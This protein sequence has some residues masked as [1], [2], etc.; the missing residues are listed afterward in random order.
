MAYHLWQ[1]SR[2]V[3][4]SASEGRYKIPPRCIV[5]RPDQ[6]QYYL[7]RYSSYSM[8]GIILRCHYPYFEYLLLQ[9]HL[10]LC[11]RGQPRRCPPARGGE[12][13]EENAVARIFSRLASKRGITAAKKFGKVL[14]ATCTHAGGAGSAEHACLQRKALQCNASMQCNAEQH[15]CRQE[16]QRLH[17]QGISMHGA[18]MHC[19]RTKRPRRVEEAGQQGKKRASMPSCT[20]PEKPAGKAAREEQHR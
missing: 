5:G 15:A 1:H 7:K 17:E 3:D 2:V 8:G 14:L 6:P 13:E 16:Q 20:R 19:P 10:L 18:H 4:T 12:R 9:Q 11:I